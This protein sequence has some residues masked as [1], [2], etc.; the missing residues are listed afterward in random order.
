[1][2]IC[3]CIY[4]EGLGVWSPTIENQMEKTWKMKWTPGLGFPSLHRWLVPGLCVSILHNS[5]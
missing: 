2:Y 1:M 5:L 3:V 4:I